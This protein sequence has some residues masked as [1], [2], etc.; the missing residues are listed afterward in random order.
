MKVKISI[1][2]IFPLSTD[3]GCCYQ[4]KR[5]RFLRLCFWTR[6]DV[7]SWTSPPAYLTTGIHDFPTSG[8]SC[9][10][11]FFYTKQRRLMRNPLSLSSCDDLCCACQAVDD[12]TTSM[13]R[14]VPGSTSITPG[15]VNR[16][17]EVWSKEPA[18]C[19][20]C[21]C[22]SANWRCDWR[23]GKPLLQASPG[24]NKRC[25]STFLQ[26]RRCSCWIHPC[27]DSGAAVLIWD[28]RKARAV[29]RSGFLGGRRWWYQLIDVPLDDR[30]SGCAWSWSASLSFF[31]SLPFVFFFTYPADVCTHRCNMRCGWCSGDQLPYCT[32]F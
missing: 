21:A 4:L 31:V 24:E 22:F 32:M 1:L 9:L 6:G 25:R 23:V 18:C 16:N 2:S 19:G 29:W 13:M 17:A 5:C 15:S 30:C 12:P 28:M 10:S 14:N 20:L 8:T 11:F 3:C 26:H 7:V 27:L